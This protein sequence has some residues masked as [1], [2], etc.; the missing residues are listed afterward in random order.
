[1]HATSAADLL[2]LDPI[3]LIIFSEQYKY[4]PR[5]YTAARHR[6]AF[7]P[8]QPRFIKIRRRVVLLIQ[9]FGGIC[10]LHQQGR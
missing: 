1:M 2:H 7:L 9:H 6:C 5:Q 4:E 3:T 8:K 10:S